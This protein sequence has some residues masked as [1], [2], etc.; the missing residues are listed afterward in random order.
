MLKL[1]PYKIGFRTVKTAVGMTLGVI[2]CK[3]LGLDN[4]AS[5]AILVVLCIKHTKMHSVQ[6]ILSRLVSCL[7]IL[8]LGSAIFS[9]LGQHAFVLGLIVLLF[10]P[11]K[12]VLNVQEGVITS[13]VILLHVFNAKAINGHLILNEIMLLI[14]GLGIA[15]LMNLMMPS[16]DKKLNHFK[17][18]IENQI[19]EIFNIFSQA[20]SMHNDHL[21]I[22]FDSLLLNIKKAKSLAF[23]DVKNHFVRNENSFYHY[24]DMR[25]EQVELLKRMTSLLERINTDDPILEKISQ[26]MYE[27][28]S[29]VNSNDYTALR[30]HSLYEIRLS[31]DDLPLPTTHKTLNSRAHI[32]QILN[33]LEEYLNIKSQFGS[34]KLHSEI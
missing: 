30:L 10:I 21:N 8:F 2:I 11:L 31:L 7:L 13:C 16:L 26:L 18:D 17:Q 34:L 22:K 28:G 5:S 15:F 33:E 9:L 14:V 19:T 4:Y 25:E 24:F 6:A 1:N 23:R 32:I 20:C 27:I 12:V 3:L 29:N